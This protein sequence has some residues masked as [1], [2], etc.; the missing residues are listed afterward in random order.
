MDELIDTGSTTDGGTNK[1]ILHVLVKR[2][3][4]PVS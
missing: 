2:F 3:K 1:V 4:V